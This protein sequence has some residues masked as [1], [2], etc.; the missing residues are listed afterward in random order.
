[1][2]KQQSIQKSLCIGAFRWVPL[3]ALS[4][5]IFQVSIVYWCGWLWRALGILEVEKE[6]DWILVAEISPWR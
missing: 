3:K 1:V 6:A 2:I 4:Y 5:Q